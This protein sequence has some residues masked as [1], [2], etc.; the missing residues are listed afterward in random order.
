MIYKIKNLLTPRD[1]EFL[2]GLL[3]FSIII[4]IVEMLGVSLI[5]P[6][7]AIATD[8]TLIHSNIYYDYMY[9]FFGFSNDIKFVVG[10]GI[11]LVVFYLFRSM[12]NLIYFYLLSRFTQGRYHLLSA[13]LFQKYMAMPYREYVSINSSNLTKNIVTEAHNLTQLIS[14]LLL[15]LSEIF[16]VVLIYGMM[17]YFNAKITLLLTLVLGF[18]AFLML[19]IVSVK[20]KEAGTLRAEAQKI[21]YEIIN[22]SFGNFKLIKLQD[23]EDDI[24]S[25]F[26]QASYAYAEA[27]IVNSTLSHV[28]R[29]FFEAIGFSLIILIVTYL[30]WK[31]ETN[32]TAML[33]LIS[34]FVVAL[35]RLMPSVNRIM[36]SYNQMLFYYKSL[37]IIH[38]DLLYEG[39]HL[40]DK[41][42]LFTQKIVIDNLSFGYENNQ[43]ILKDINLT[44]HKGE[45]IAFIGESGS[46][47]STLVD[48]I[49]GL[50]L[51]Q[52]GKI[53]VD[54]VEVCSE[55]LKAWRT[56]VGYIPQTVYLFDGT[57]GENVS[58]GFDY[59]KKRIEE[60]LKKAKI[61]DF[62]HTKEG[63][64]TLVGEGG[65]MLSGG[66]KQRIAIA[67][68]LYNNPEIL[69][70]D[71]ATS[72]LDD[73][74]EQQIM[75]EIYDISVDKTLI[76]IAHRLST[77]DKCEKIYRL[78]KGK[79]V[80]V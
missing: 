21:F 76:I 42:I 75:N 80:E 19:K 40:G 77:L 43:S 11:L 31:Y 68:A 58:F 53:F 20:I 4:S 16:I 54:G 24:L 74:I 70:L 73:K 7:I 1:K 32:V 37:D 72:A 23:K 78:E 18:N 51:P 79:L 57:V 71:E 8:F 6:F 66:Q 56:K 28:P 14:S 65:I 2:Y 36:S 15:M 9:T 47:K 49:I 22:R 33:S 52:K 13:R 46:G 26:Q 48:N 29:L 27:N 67:R 38:H 50:Y 55:N 34:M 30:V 64:D 69:V 60:V 10:F 35:Y 59:D 61:Y 44:I 17:L 63:V 62:L 5:M 3:F 41:S 39:E 25:N 45:K 12:I